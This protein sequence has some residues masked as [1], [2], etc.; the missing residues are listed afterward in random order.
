[1]DHWPLHAQRWAQVGP[2]LRPSA[3]DVA[4]VRAA[5]PEGARMLVL[6]VTPE[7][8]AL[9]ARE[10]VAVDRD[11]AMIEALF[12]PGPGRR[13]LQGDW[14]ALPVEAASFDAASGDGCASFFAFPDGYHAF[15]EELARVLRPGGV[16]S[17]RVFVSPDAPESLAEVDAGLDAVQGFDALKWRIAM[18]LLSPDRSVAVTAIRAGFEE[19]APDRVAFAAR[20]GWPLEKV[21]VIDHYRGSPAVYS[22]PRLGEVRACFDPWFE[23]TACAVGRYELAE[24][25]PTLVWR[26][27]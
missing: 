21:A 26:R 3:E 2:P 17:L 13:A 15:A 10:V 1:M 7:L 4:F 23:E 11:P 5:L 16:L 25:C 27:R 14:R 6:G 18:A 19:L 22:F 20:K 24:R 8:V 9:P 12:T